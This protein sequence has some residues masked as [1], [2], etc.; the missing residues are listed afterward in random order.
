MAAGIGMSVAGAVL[1]KKSDKIEK[2]GETTTEKSGFSV[3]K[4][5][6][7]GWTL[8]GAGIVATVGGTV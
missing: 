7:A 1:V 5:Y 4:P 2:S 6:V 3:T 8:L